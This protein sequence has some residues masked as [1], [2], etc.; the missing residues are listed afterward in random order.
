VPGISGH[1]ELA[2]S[3]NRHNL[4]GDIGFHFQCNHGVSAAKGAIKT[5]IFASVSY[6]S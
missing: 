3:Y 2:A 5:Q 1:W 4:L 6:S